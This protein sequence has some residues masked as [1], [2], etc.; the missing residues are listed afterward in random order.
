MDITI[1]VRV[2]WRL[3]EANPNWPSFEE[4]IMELTFN[5]YQLTLTVRLRQSKKRTRNEPPSAQ[6]TAPDQHNRHYRLLT[7]GGTHVAPTR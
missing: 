2:L 6:P 7:C 5:G 3:Q 1:H 4:E